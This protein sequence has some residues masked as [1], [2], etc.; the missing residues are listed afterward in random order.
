MQNSWN[1]IRA[2]IKAMELAMF[3]LKHS[4]HKKLNEGFKK[5]LWK[6]YDFTISLYNGEKEW[7]F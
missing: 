6:N 1:G 5:W 4:G 3:L 7:T 2:F